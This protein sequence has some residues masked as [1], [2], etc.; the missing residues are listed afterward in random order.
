MP[1]PVPVAA[2][3]GLDAGDD[4]GRCGRLD[5]VVVGAEAEAADLVVVAAAGAQKQDRHLGGGP[6]LAAE[7]EPRSAREHHVEQ[8]AVRR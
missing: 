3:D 5:D 1:P 6:D 8:H 2:E 4:L 7:V